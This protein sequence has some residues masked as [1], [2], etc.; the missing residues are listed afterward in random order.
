MP[1]SSWRNFLAKPFVLPCSRRS[2]G[3]HSRGRRFRPQ[4]MPLEDRTLPAVVMWTNPAGGDWD[5]PGNWSTGAVPG[6]ADDAV[7]AVSGIT[8]THSAGATDSIR[9]PKQL[10]RCV[11]CSLCNLKNHACAAIAE[12]KQRWFPSDRARKSAYPRA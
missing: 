3:P 5:T 6:A 1:A 11:G 7:I 12:R 10:K 2:A 9:Q 8:V 4:L